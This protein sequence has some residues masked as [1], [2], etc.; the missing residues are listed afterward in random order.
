MATFPRIRVTAVKGC[1]NG[2]GTVPS[3]SIKD[4]DF[5]FGE[6]QVLFGVSLDLAPKTVTAI[7]GPSGCGKSTILRTLNRI[8]EL[9]PDRRAEGAVM[10]EGR[11]ILSNG[12]DLNL[13]RGKI[14]MIF[15]TATPF[16][17]SVYENVAWGI[18]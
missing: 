9:Y 10:F 2:A 11:N 4:L 18:C 6:K 5:W 8:Y 1:E 7:I 15:Q 3:I 14:G 16:P 13:L 17:M 12:E